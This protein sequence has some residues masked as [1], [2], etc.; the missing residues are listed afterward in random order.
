MQVDEHVGFAGKVLTAE[1]NKGGL[2]YAWEKKH[3]VS[4]LS[5]TR[6]PVTKELAVKVP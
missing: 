5:K 6:N 2:L 1:C 3:S 4:F